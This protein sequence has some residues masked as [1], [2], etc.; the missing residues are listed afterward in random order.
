SLLNRIPGFRPS[1]DR[2]KD[3]IGLILLAAVASCMV[4]A[5]VGVA[6][7]YL[8]GIVRASD[9]GATWAAWWLGGAVRGLVVAPVLL[10]W[11]GRGGRSRLAEAAGLCALLLLASYWVF[12]LQSAVVALFY[13]LLIWAAIRFELPGAARA[14]FLIAAIA[15]W[16][17]ARGRGPFI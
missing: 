10:A 9:L 3:V 6:S 5:T 17:T 4:S 12:E 14:T 11:R 1:L 15:I 7:L 13:P 16:A 8:G 2:L